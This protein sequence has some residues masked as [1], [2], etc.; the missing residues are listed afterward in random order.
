VD[1]ETANFRLRYDSNGDVTDDDA[2]PL[3][4][5]ATPNRSELAFART[6][7]LAHPR[8]VRRRLARASSPLEPVAAWSDPPMFLTPR[9]RPPLPAPLRNRRPP[10]PIAL[11]PRPVTKAEHEFDDAYFTEDPDT[12]PFR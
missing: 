5:P 11:A 1:D 4:L 7:P 2:A 9:Q 8:L 6:E 10:T 3:H 12:Q